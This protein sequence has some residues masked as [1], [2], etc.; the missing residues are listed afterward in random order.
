MNQLLW[1]WDLRIFGNNLWWK[2][3]WSS[4]RAD[5]WPFF[6]SRKYAKV[7]FLFKVASR[8]GY[9]RSVQKPV[10]LSVCLFKACIWCFILPIFLQTQ[11]LCLLSLTHTTQELCLLYFIHHSFIY[12]TNLPPLK[13]TACPNKLYF[14]SLSSNPLK[15]EV[16]LNSTNEDFFFLGGARNFTN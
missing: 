7:N 11:E 8:C 6:K 13:F 1:L 16:F 4:R 9:D 12:T 10:C 3:L 14:Y 5:I 15:F 2:P